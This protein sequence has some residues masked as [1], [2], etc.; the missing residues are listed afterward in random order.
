VDWLGVLKKLHSESN[1]IISKFIDVGFKPNSAFE[2]QALM[3]LNARYCQPRNC[4]NC[5]IGSN[6]LK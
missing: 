3:Q 6:M 1:S 2:S 4:V 5:A